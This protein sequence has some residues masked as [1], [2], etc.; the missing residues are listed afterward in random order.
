M[1]ACCKLHTISAWMSGEGGDILQLYG[2]DMERVN[3]YVEAIEH[4]HSSRTFILL[5]FPVTVFPGLSD[6]PAKY[7]PDHNETLSSEEGFTTTSDYS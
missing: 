5:T 2:T 1:S 7:F 3:A 6:S 4:P